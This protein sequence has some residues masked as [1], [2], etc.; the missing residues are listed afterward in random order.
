M[1]LFLLAAL[2]TSLPLA[3]L[4]WYWQGHKIQ[5]GDYSGFPAEGIG[6]GGK[7]FG[8]DEADGAAGS[9]IFG[10]AAGVMGF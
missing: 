10:A 9:G 8:P 6:G 7:L 2:S 1:L 5:A 3:L 4:R